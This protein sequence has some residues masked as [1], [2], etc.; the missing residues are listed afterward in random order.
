MSEVTLYRRTIPDV[1]FQ[2]IPPEVPELGDLFREKHLK[3][4]LT[5]S[6]VKDILQK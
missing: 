5:Q 4:Y 2:I 1:R 6:V 3:C